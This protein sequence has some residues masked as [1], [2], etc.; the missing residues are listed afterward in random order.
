MET[1]GYD[2]ATAR[3]IAAQMKEDD[4]Q[5]RSPEY[6]I[7]ET[8]EREQA[9]KDATAKLA[10]D[11]V[12]ASR[13]YIE[14][15]GGRIGVVSEAEAAQLEAVSASNAMHYA[16]RPTNETEERMKTSADFYKAA[17]A[18]IARYTAQVPWRHTTV[19]QVDFAGMVEDI[20]EKEAFIVLQNAGYSASDA[21]A[22]VADAKEFAAAQ[23]SLAP[24]TDS[25]GRINVIDAVRN[26]APES[27]LRTMGIDTNTIAEARYY[28]ATIVEL[29][30]V[31]KAEVA[32]IAERIM[33]H[34]PVQQPSMQALWQWASRQYLEPYKVGE[35]T[36]DIRAAL[37]NGVDVQVLQWAGVAGS[38]RLL[39]GMAERPQPIKSTATVGVGAKLPDPTRAKPESEVAKAGGVSGIVAAIVLLP[40]RNRDGSY[41]LQ[42]IIE[43]N[44]LTVGQ[45]R[46]AGF[47]DAQITS[48]ITSA[49]QANAARAALEIQETMASAQEAPADRATTSPI[50]TAVTIDRQRDIADNLMVHIDPALPE[51][52]VIMPKL[53]ELQQYINSKTRGTNQV[54]RVAGGAA[55]GLSYAIMPVAMAEDLLFTPGWSQKAQR[56]ESYVKG[57]VSYFLTLP[58]AFMN[59]PYWTIGEVAGMI[60]GPKAAIKE[61][62]TVRVWVDPYGVPARAVGIEFSTGKAPIGNLSK[63]DLGRAVAEAERQILA[64]KLSG[65]VKVGSAE[66]KYRGT[67]IQHTVGEV[68]FNATTD[69]A[70]VAG[71]DVLKVPEGQGMYFSPYVAPRFMATSAGG[72][73][74]T[75]PGV[76]AVLTDASRIRD[77]AKT[78]LKRATGSEKFIL[79]A[80]EGL[81]GPSK[82]YRHSFETEVVASPG[83]TFT[84]VPTNLRTRILGEKA[85][86]FFV[87]YDGPSVPG[88]TKGQLVPVHVFVDKGVYRTAPSP[89]ALYA[90]KLLTM[91]E[92]LKDIGQKVMH[93]SRTIRD[94]LS[95]S[96]TAGVRA[97]ET[98]PTS[99]M[100]TLMQE[101]EREAKATARTEKAYRAAL[102][103]AYE[104]RAAALYERVGRSAET[105]YAR[106]PAAFERAY[107]SR[108]EGNLRT[109]ARALTVQR[110]YETVR[111]EPRRLPERTVRD[112][113]EW[114]RE[115][116]EEPERT[117]RDES[118]RIAREPR[119]EL[120]RAPAP[121]RT[122]PRTPPPPPPP[123]PRR[124]PVIPTETTGPRPPKREVVATNNGHRMEDTGR[125]QWK[126]GAYWIMVEPPAVEGER[127]RNVQYSRR[128]FWGVRKVKG[129][130]EETFSRQGTPP[131]EF[132]Y[133]M[134]V[135]KARIHS[136][137]KPHLRWRQTSKARRRRGRLI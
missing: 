82:I 14:S 133:E 57:S 117:T 56:A 59:D 23:K 5:S 123:P 73:L 34:V 91:Y 118:S 26:D 45:M 37:D 120:R 2:I 19:T 127:Q 76:I 114:M 46:Q 104:S 3:R 100:R 58:V 119:A 52:G 48:A 38:D 21:R 33:T 13:E 31:Q 61:A 35:N 18:Q 108:L 50:L 75:K 90:A 47:T 44:K 107:A 137:E 17:A 15:I 105:A 9:A 135:T 97:V 8:R 11:R 83:T 111:E 136:Y 84:K 69:V 87:Q 63:A 93:P 112:L 99:A 27:A 98:Q 125:V 43:D 74:A 70:R 16:F 94:A 49:Q 7:A 77:V 71:K 95:R 124:I 134:G 20:G 4:R 39:A 32:P 121:P 96:G 92:S 110:A 54:L 64:G 85:G 102:V 130:P 28:A 55:V 60:A 66:V 62:R 113:P 81:Y 30:E 40:Y 103:K 53:Q 80:D 68:A 22:I 41:N 51:S 131:R 72:R 24:Y 29:P 109:A 116:R 101:L 78:A 126:Q 42:R 36:Y 132:L 1:R 10:V 115:A 67:P 6:G 25:M 122:P 106:A 65:T 86:E 89:S 12:E 88:L 129:S 128:P 79:R